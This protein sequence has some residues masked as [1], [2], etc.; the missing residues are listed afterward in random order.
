MRHLIALSLLGLV[1]L[2]AVAVLYRQGERGIEREAERLAAEAHE[3]RARA[4]EAVRRELLGE[5]EG[6][7]AREG[8]RPFY[9]WRH[10]YLPPDLV[11]KNVALVP[12]PLA[13]RPPDPRV[14]L[15]FELRGGQ[16]TSPA[17][18]GQ[19]SCAVEE[20]PSAW[21]EEIRPRLVELAGM[22]AVLEAT[23]PA[24]QGGAAPGP[25]DSLERLDWFVC[26]TNAAPSVA[27]NAAQ[28]LEEARYAQDWQQYQGRQGKLS[29]R[30]EPR[31]KGEGQTRGG[32]LEV[33]RTPFTLRELGARGADG[34]PRWVIAARWVIV[35]AELGSGVAGSWLQGFALDLTHLRDDALPALVRR[36]VPPDDDPDPAL[37][38][39]VDTLMRSGGSSPAHRASPVRVVPAARLIDGSRR[40]GSGVAL[41][42][43]LEGVGLLHE[44]PLPDPRQLMRGSRQLLL[45]ALVLALLVVALGAVILVRATLAERRLARQRSDFVA[46]LTHELKAPLTGIRALSELLHE[47]LV[48]DEPR[49][50]EYYGSI[51]GESE[52][53]GRL[54][55][56]VLDA[57]RL[58]RG[59]ALQL[60][61]GEVAVGPLLGDLARHARPR[62]EAAGADLEVDLGELP[63][64]RADRE[65]V[66]QVVANLL[67][68]ALKYGRAGGAPARIELRAR[69]EGGRVV[70]EVR[71]HGPGIPPGERGR[72]FE[73]FWRSPAAPRE[74]G[75][76]GLGL[77]IAR[78]QARAMGGD[79]ALVPVEG[80]GACFRLELPCA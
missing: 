70:V 55:Q 44:G 19:Q 63:P 39:R 67:D 7:L 18:L 34:W 37:S 56:N 24:P 3:T 79:L 26:Q 50:R 77:W 49:R 47:G 5:L 21:A 66:G 73:R 60:A 25:F 40:P 10:L 42:A 23:F 43:P 48:S 1:L 74:V 58:E 45:G 64:A 76:A 78:A 59:A 4:L 38:L 52:R 13:A 22:S 36:V 2:A 35:P 53:L 41:S 75:G 17:F 20:A 46:A 28:E 61:C 51:L 65:A 16:L 68:N 12:S 8:E 9:H 80:P 57:S 15:Y 14:G 72:V 29:G 32:E 6:L 30:Y 71:D 54:V 62:L 33:R 69:A 27:L 31:S 11:A